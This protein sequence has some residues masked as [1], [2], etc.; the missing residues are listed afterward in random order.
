VYVD[1]FKRVLDI[2][3][4][5]A[6]LTVFFPIFIIAALLIKL[7]SKGP[8]FF[9][10]VRVGRGLQDITV[11]K[12][13]TMVH[14]KREVGDKPIIG[15]APDVTYVGYVLRRFKMDEFPQLINVLIGDMTLVGPR[16]S[17]RKQLQNM[18]EREKERYSVRPGLTGLAQVSGNI[19][20]SWPE[21]YKFDLEYIDNISMMNDLRILI[22][23][24]LLIFLSIGSTLLF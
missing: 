17:I 7:E 15:K 3:I 10:Q 23:T 20:L 8:I 14:K 5:L 22:R 24:F 6:V 16:P 21:R 9:T 13:R 2:V 18:S 4:A 19:H 12:L 11:Y 1:F